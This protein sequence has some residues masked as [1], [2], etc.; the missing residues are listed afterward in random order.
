MFGGL[1][2]HTFGSLKQ[3]GSLKR[4]AGMQYT[5]RCCKL[6]VFGDGRMALRMFVYFLPEEKQVKFGYKLL[7]GKVNDLLMEGSV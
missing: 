4:V 3:G 5:A 7:T 2:G 6:T 1:L